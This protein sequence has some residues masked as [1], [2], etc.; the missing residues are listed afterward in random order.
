MINAETHEWSLSAEK[1][2]KILQTID[3]VY[4]KTDLR[5]EVSVTTKAGQKL[6][7]KLIALTSI[8]PPLNRYLMFL[9]RDLVAVLKL[10]PEQNK[11]AEQYQDKILTFSLRA[12]RD[13]HFIRAVLASIHQCWIPIRN[14]ARPTP[15]TADVVVHVSTTNTYNIHNVEHFTVSD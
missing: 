6:L 3:K 7:G 12:K 4:D 11:M 5:K 9:S 1:N 8:F 2:S 13:L 14:P 10:R 15:V